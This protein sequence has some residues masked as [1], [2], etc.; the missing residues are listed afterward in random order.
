MK[1][2]DKLAQLRRKNGLSQ[3][4]LGDQLNVTR[5]T[6]SKWELGQSKPDTDKLIE[7]S[8]LLNVDLNQLIDDDATICDNLSE[9]EVTSNEV[10]PR[11]WLLVL[12]II[13]A[14]CIVIVLINKVVTDRKARAESDSSWGIFSIFNGF[15]GFSDVEKEV[16]N[17]SFEFYV[18]TKYGSSVSNLLDKVIT[19]NKTDSGHMI[20]VVFGDMNTSKSDEIKD[21][22]KDLQTFDQYEVLVDYDENGYANKVTIE[23]V[24]GSSDSFNVSLFNGTF[25]LYAGT[26]YGTSVSNLLEKVITNNKTNSDH[27]LRVVYGDINTTEESEIRNLKKN[28]DDWTEYEVIFDY[29]ENGYIMQVVIED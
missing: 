19:N 15:N 3:E 17:S 22:K 2:G 24:S 11:K 7:I 25:E 9:S 26:K 16:F 18:G 1:F 8:K 20:V 6:I 4:E 10:R 14:I 29:D 13:V 5:Q 21:M 12:L 27:I 23:T 28:L